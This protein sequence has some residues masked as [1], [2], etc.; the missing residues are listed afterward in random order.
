MLK[1]WRIAFLLTALAMLSV[2]VVACGSSTG[3]STPS[4]STPTVA[5]KTSSINC[6]TGNLA[7]GGSTAL[8]PL[9]Q[10]AA[11]AYQA[12]CSGATITTQLTGSGAGLKGAHDGSLNI[13]SSDNFVSLTKNPEYKDL[14]D[15]QVAVVIFS[16]IISKDV[17]GVTNLTSA[18][19]KDIYTGK[20]TNWKQ[21][22]GPDLAITVISRASGS[23]TRNT[24]EKYILA[25]PETISGANHITA[26]SSGDVASNVGS[27]SG[28][29][30][31]DTIDFATKHSLTT[32]SIDGAA[33]TQDNVKTNTYKFWNI[34][35]MYTKGDAT[36]LAK[37]FID[38]VKSAD[39]ASLRQKD[40]FMDLSAVSAD[41]IA[42][43]TPAAAK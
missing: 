40:G 23:G 22:G 8:G 38:Y 21:V 3:G 42:A 28:A 11:K 10:D 32:V 34:E 19:I 7:T 25:T 18:Q 26:K 12:A 9:V 13:G 4:T 39:A 43:K 30:A 6:A 14:T 36:G 20:V 31:Y 5:A 37:S 15:N 35:H 41:A 16:V 2:F 24:F 1:K 29:I 33:P 27:K 17:T